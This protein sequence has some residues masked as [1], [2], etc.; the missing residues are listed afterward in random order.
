M[1]VERRLPPG[2]GVLDVF[3]ALDTETRRRALAMLPEIEREALDREWRAWAHDGQFVPVGPEGED[4][5]TWV[6]KGGR[7]FG[8]T[9][10]G[11]Q[12]IESLIAAHPEVPLRI[13]LVGA[14]IDDARRVMVEGPSG[15]LQVADRWV[16][17]WHRT[18]GRLRFVTGAE[19][20]L[21]SGACPHLLR[22]PAHHFAWCDEL[23]KWEHSQ[24]AWDMLQLGLREG[25]RPRALVTTT[26]QSGSVLAAIM[27]EPDTRVSG[28]PTRANRHLPRAFRERV[29]RLYEGTRLGRQELDGEVLPNVAGALWTVELIERCRVEPS[30]A[31]PFERTVIA[32]DPPT[33]A[34]TCGIVACAREGSGA[35]AV[36]HVVADHSVTD[37]SPESWSGAVAAAA[38]A[39]GTIDVVA[40]ANQGGKMV[41]AV[42][43]TA[44]P[45][46]RVRL[47]NAHT[48]KAARAEPVSHLFEAGRARLHGRMPELEAQLLGFVAGGGYE[49]PGDSPDRADAMVWG[50]T[51]LMRDRAAPR[52]WVG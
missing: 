45:R 30:P 33:G 20:Q 16:E 28:G 26:P 17:E 25:T 13:A 15:L 31:G 44:D 27:A 5:S 43:H 10:A 18:L 35:E 49:G 9:R 32:V 51:E 3:K 52:V 46:L 23:A 50:V 34:G 41:K 38:E 4:W 22:G 7:G 36:M 21:F 24:E 40:E 48:G 8:K 1:G 11:A 2:T 42:F 12:W 39:H 29:Y 19:A 14:T 37:C 6:I 47:V